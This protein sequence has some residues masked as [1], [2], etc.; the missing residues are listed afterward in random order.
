MYLIFDTET[1][2]LPLNYNA[3][4]T[5]ISNW[6]RVVQLAW[7][8]FSENAEII[9]SHNYIIKPENFIIPL[10]STRIHGISHEHAMR[11]G[12]PLRTILPRF[13]SAVSGSQ[14]AIAHNFS[15]D[16]RIL[17]AEAIRHKTIIPFNEKK[18]LCTMKA[19]TNFCKIP[20]TR[21][22]KWPKLSELHEVLFNEPF[23]AHNA[24]KD[25][26]ACARCFFEL[27]KKGA[28]IL[29]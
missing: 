12:V 18:S 2:G 9:D 21:G 17:E 27:K 23:N 22:Y 10:D 3:P 4:S 14:L 19:S 28:L 6:P 7:A 11:E 1:T 29:P 15:F 8:Q 13:S 5:D 16:Q 25:V 26:E 24:E 20:N